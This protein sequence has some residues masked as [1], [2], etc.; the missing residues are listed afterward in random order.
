MS[1]PQHADRSVEV[2]A[3]ATIQ[4]GE[5]VCIR[6]L[7]DT[8]VTSH[9]RR[10][11]SVLSS[12]WLIPAHGGAEAAA[13]QKVVLHVRVRAVPGQVSCD[14]WRAGQYSPLIG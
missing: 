14:W 9:W 6:Y 10:P 2:R 11:A 3:L 8:Q 7:A 1:P 4:P 12:D 13:G 5:E